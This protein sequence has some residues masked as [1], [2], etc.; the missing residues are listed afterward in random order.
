MDSFTVFGKMF[1]SIKLYNILYHNINNHHCLQVP[2]CEPEQVHDPSSG[3]DLGAVGGGTQPVGVTAGVEAPADELGLSG[4]AVR[5][6]LI[7]HG[8]PHRVNHIALLHAIRLPTGLNT[9]SL[10]SLSVSRYLVKSSFT[11]CDKTM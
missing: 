4:R 1:R 10:A 9:S 3:R 7:H 8:Q 2:D 6:G 11:L 5:G